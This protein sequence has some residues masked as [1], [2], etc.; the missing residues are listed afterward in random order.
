MNQG[1]C[2][3]PIINYPFQNL[4]FKAERDETNMAA[5]K[6][7][8]LDATVSTSTPTPRLHHRSIV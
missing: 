6:A 2:M 4:I 7:T 3:F 8:L 5:R 1:S